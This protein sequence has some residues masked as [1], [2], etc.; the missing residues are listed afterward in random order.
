MSVQTDIEENG[1]RVVKLQIVNFKKVRALDITPT[2]N[3]VRIKGKNGAGKS[4]VLDAIWACV[5]GKDAS[6]EKPIRDE[7]ET[8]EVSLDM[9]PIRLKRVWKKDGSSSLTIVGKNGEKIKGPQ[10]LLDDFI[11]NA[12]IDPGWFIHMD[13]KK[14]KEILQQVI[15]GDLTA[16]D[17]ER[18]KLFNRRQDANRDAKSAKAKVDALSGN[19]DGSKEEQSTEVVLKELNDA[20]DQDKNNK[21]KRSSLEEW[22]KDIENT[23]KLVKDHKAQVAKWEQT[24]K[25]S[26][27]ARDEVKNQVAELKDPDI[28]S[29]K[30]KLQKL[31]KTNATARENAAKSTAID[32]SSVAEKKAKELDDAIKEIDR[33]KEDAFKNANLPIDGLALGEDGIMLGDIPFAQASKSEQLTAAFLIACRSNPTLKILT[34]RDGSLFDSESQAKLQTLAK[35]EGVDLW[36]EIVSEDGDG[37]LEIEEVQ[38]G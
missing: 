27:T 37:S 26:V 2:T 23:T 19:A 6:P 24:L 5:G 35:Q 32:E 17:E 33:K 21:E 13:P 34:I 4:S 1:L 29:V 12:T 15:G 31:D 28:D 38:N 8:A 16:L 18:D 22:E 20:M 30:E 25:E 9:G 7:E 10:T 3:V 14:Q 11:G 36:L